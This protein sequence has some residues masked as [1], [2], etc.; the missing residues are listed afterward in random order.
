MRA[1]EQRGLTLIELTVALAIAVLLFSGAVMGIGALVGVKAKSAA[2]ELSATLRSLYDTAALTGKTCRLVFALPDPRDEDASTRYWAE[3]A[4]GAVT[5]TKDREGELKERSSERKEDERRASSLSTGEDGER[6]KDL[7]S[8]EKDRVEGAAKFAE[9]T[10]PEI[11]AREIPS[12]VR[13]SVWTKHQREAVTS[14][15]AYVYFFPQGFTER[16]Q[17]VVSQD[18]NAWTISVAPLTGKTSVVAEALEVPR[19]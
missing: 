8:H 17:I 19:S 16:A 11:E 2:G 9:F 4:A 7:L 5:T 6:L 10:T 15:A 12:S 13:L 18:D 3:C 1:R 14:G